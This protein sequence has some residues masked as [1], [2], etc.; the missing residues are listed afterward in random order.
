[1]GRYISNL[2]YSPPV[3]VE[4]PS[5]IGRTETAAMEMLEEAGLKGSV[6]EDR[7]ARDNIPSGSVAIQEPPA[8]TPVRPGSTV[9]LT[10]SKGPATHPA[11][12]LIG[13]TQ[14]SAM[15]LLSNLGLILGNVETINDSETPEGQ[16]M[17]QTPDPDTPL[18]PGR[19][20]DIIVSLG[21]VVQL[22]RVQSFVGM[23]VADAQ[24]A[25]RK[26]DI[27]FGYT[28]YEMSWTYPKDTIMRQTPA[29]ETQ[30]Q[31]G[32]PINIVIS[33]GPGPD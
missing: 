18:L 21:P 22:V 5:V 29:P 19:A 4:S 16:I 7:V 9:L 32:T 6:Q 11:P 20:V 3:E 13:E 17:G 25:A 14:Q 27:E 2:L 12:D 10:L 1:M 8:Y 28:S 24:E 23:P 31:I 15:I 33:Q 26:L 30:M